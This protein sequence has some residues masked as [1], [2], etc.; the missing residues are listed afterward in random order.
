MHNFVNCS[1]CLIVEY[2]AF[3]RSLIDSGWEPIEI[4]DRSPSLYSY[5]WRKW[6]QEAGHLQG[7]DMFKTTRGWAAV[8]LVRLK[9]RLIATHL[10][11]F[12]FHL[13]IEWRWQH[14]R[15][16]LQQP[17]AWLYCEPAT[18]RDTGAV[19]SL[20]DNRTPVAWP[21]KPYRSQV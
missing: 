14:R 18:R 4:E 20:R 12:H 8:A 3:V 21:G 17:H 10:F 6:R 2:V 7:W 19:R 13:Q 11:Y 16:Q 15:I 5:W 1:H 9:K